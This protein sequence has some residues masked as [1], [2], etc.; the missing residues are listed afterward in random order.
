MIQVILAKSYKE[1]KSFLDKQED[2]W[3]A[4]ETEYGSEV[5][6]E[7]CEA[8]D[9]S[10]NHHGDLQHLEAPAL[11]YKNLPK[12]RFDNF[13]ISHIDLDVLFGILW[14]AGW[15]K[16]TRTTEILSELIAIADTKG[17]HVI[18]PLLS[19]LKPHIA[20]KYY[21]IGYLVNSWVIND[22]GEKLV[23]ISKEIHKL[24]LRI[25]DIILSGATEDQIL[26][27]TNWFKEQEKAAKNYLK[28]IK[29]LCD[30]KNMF[31]FRA[32]FSLTTAYSI[33][34]IQ[35]EIIV[36]YNEQ[37][38]SISLSC[39]DEEVAG[40]YFG[41]NGVITPLKDF[42]GEKAG[43]KKTIGGTPRDQNIQPEML[44]AFIEF[45]YREYFNI[46]EIESLYEQIEITGRKTVTIKDKNLLLSHKRLLPEILRRFE[47]EV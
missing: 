31:I 39:F 42:F 47:E 23:D 17:F 22:N 20:Q 16:K 32:P 28:E 6:D 40:T 2:K 27:Y 34:D 5:I 36:Q 38:K 13:I 25:K 11:V 46:P 29:P 3:V 45:L 21:A 26:L 24:L 43:G 4:I 14:T 12:K 10:L 35:A 33:G 30:G 15:L 9:L 41:A 44:S 8:V 37:S 7:K 1:A 18:K 19:D